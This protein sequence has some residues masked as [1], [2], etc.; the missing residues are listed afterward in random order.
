MTLPASISL[1]RIRS[2]EPFEPANGGPSAPPWQA[3]L[4][5]A[6]EGRLSDMSASAVAA[7]VAANGAGRMR[8][9]GSLASSSMAGSS[10][11]LDTLAV[12]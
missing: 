9:R 12:D 4:N 7:A 11:S 1:Q 3:A 2:G 8:K 10:V 5:A 6:A